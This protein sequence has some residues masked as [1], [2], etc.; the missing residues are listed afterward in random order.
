MFKCR[1]PGSFTCARNR[2]AMG[3]IQALHQGRPGGVLVRGRE[4]EELGD[5]VEGN[6]RMLDSVLVF[7]MFSVFIKK[8]PQ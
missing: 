5:G 3:M 7:D 1:Q 4:S 2:H 6:L 8:P